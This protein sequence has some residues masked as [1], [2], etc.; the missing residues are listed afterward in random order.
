MA[1]RPAPM[2]FAAANI[3]D[4]LYFTPFALT[5]VKAIKNPCRLPVFLK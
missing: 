2:Y 3:V 1:A 4:V 5:F